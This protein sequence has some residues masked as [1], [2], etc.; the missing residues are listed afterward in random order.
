MQLAN[1]K[2]FVPLMSQSII[3]R[4]LRRGSV[5]TLTLKASVAAGNPYEATSGDAASCS[6]FTVSVMSA[7]IITPQ[8]II[9]GSTIEADP[10][11]QWPELTIQR[12]YN[13][14]GI[15]FFE[16]SANEQGLRQ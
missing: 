13:Q 2:A 5:D 11:A 8:A 12:I 6:Q 16:C 14:G 15:T 9:Q 7:A 1:P 3:L 4:N 10:F